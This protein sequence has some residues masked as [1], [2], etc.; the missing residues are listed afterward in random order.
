MIEVP[1]ATRV[2]IA[3]VWTKFITERIDL[4]RFMAQFMAADLGIPYPTGRVTIDQERSTPDRVV[5][6]I[7]VVQPADYIELRLTI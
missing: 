7:E 4:R 3:A 5:A 1:F 6:N 2:G